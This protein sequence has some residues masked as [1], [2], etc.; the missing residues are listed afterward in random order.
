ML[1]I[2]HLMSH[3]SKDI[4]SLGKESGTV[5][6]DETFNNKRFK[7][8]PFSTTPVLEQPKP[9]NQGEIFARL[10]LNQKMRILSDM[11][12]KLDNHLL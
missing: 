8:I 5:Y 9:Q 6:W 11:I 12:Y 10:E 2:M 7:G 4:I 1:L 3:V